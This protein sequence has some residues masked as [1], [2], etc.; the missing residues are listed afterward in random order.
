MEETAYLAADANHANEIRM[1]RN[2]TTI[3]HASAVSLRWD[4]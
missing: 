2:T 1:M 4:A 3:T